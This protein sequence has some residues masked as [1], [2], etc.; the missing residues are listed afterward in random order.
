M[1]DLTPAQKAADFLAAN[2]SQSY[3]SIGGRRFEKNSVMREV[4]RPY[5]TGCSRERECANA[6]SLPTGA[7]HEP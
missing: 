5:C 2:P 4:V 3:V 7:C 6:R 1:D